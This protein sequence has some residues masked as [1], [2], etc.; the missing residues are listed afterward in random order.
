M[1]DFVVQNRLFSEVIEALEKH[2][3]NLKAS[4]E[5]DCIRVLGTFICSGPLGAFDQF[6]IEC[7]IPW[8]F[9]IKEPAVWEVGGRIERT[10]SNHTYPTS[11]KCCLGHWDLWRL[12]NPNPTIETFFRDHVHSYFVSQSL[13]EQGKGWPFGEEGHSKAEAEAAYL[14]AFTF[15][16]GSDRRAFVQLIC[17]SHLKGNPLCPCGSNRYFKVCHRDF[18]RNLR[19]DIPADLRKRIRRKI[20]GTSDG[21]ADV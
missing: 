20:S 19:C 16:L 21:K 5:S 18:V 6:E 7:V 12:K 2:Q 15:P 10:V 4:L 9:P 1:P 14:D 8:T 13:S 17:G 3:P 11:G